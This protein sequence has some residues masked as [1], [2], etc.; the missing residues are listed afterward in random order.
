MLPRSSRRRSGAAVTVL[1][2]L[3]LA[4]VPT[5]G[6]AVTEEPREPRDSQSGSRA[7]APGGVVLPGLP[8]NDLT[9]LLS[10]TAS[11]RARETTPVTLRS[12]R[13]RPTPR[14]ACGRGSRPLAGLDGRVSAAA[15]GMPE[16]RRGWTCNLR[17]VARHDTPGGF[18]T[19]RYTDRRGRTCAYYDT[20]FASPLTIGSALVGPSPGVVVL[21]MTDP[22]RPRHTD[23]LTSLAML[24]PHESLNL[25]ARRGLLVAE[26]GNGLTLPGTMDVYSV[27]ADCRHPRLLS[28]VPIATGHESG[29]TA[30]GL[31]YWVA[32]A[33]GYVYAFDLTDPRRPREVWKGAYYSH[34]LSLTPDGRTLFQTD[35]INGNL[36]VLDVGQIQ[37]RRPEPRVRELRRMTWPVV[38]IP[39]NSQYFT[40]DGRRYLLEFDE[41]AFRFNPVTVANRP[42]GARIIDVSN[43]RR[44]RLVSELRLAVHVPATQRRVANDPSPLGSSGVLGYANHYCAV[45]RVRNPTIAACSTLNSGLRVFDIR[46]PAR[47][48]QVAYHVAPPRLGSRLFALQGNVA[49]SMPA[50]DVARRQIWYTDAA[51]GLYVVQLAKRAWG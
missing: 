39:Q 40:R 37:D 23:T 49:F 47:P 5:L 48:R 14:A 27:A 13:P 43:L 32:G 38:S 21:D 7:A 24:S 35:P 50:F 9:A 36:A 25:N 11:Q 42:G 41:F 46:D 30:D 20:S 34:G 3:V 12:P 15:M 6:G 2:A 16:A 10:L 8:L 18:R 29:F 33:A 44:P 22:R 51:S 45:P 28:Q 4:L 26:V 17:R 19:W 31:T 1:L